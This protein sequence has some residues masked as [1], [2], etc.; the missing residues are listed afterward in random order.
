M[1][2]KW[3]TMVFAALAAWFVPAFAS[4]QLP[5][6]NPGEMLQLSTPRGRSTSR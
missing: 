1:K 2:N 6:P 4:A 5:M 3:M